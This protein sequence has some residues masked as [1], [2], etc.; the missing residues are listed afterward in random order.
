MGVSSHRTPPRGLKFKLMSH[1]VYVLFETI[2]V[3]LPC[4]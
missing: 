1:A 3:Y 2:E 4:G